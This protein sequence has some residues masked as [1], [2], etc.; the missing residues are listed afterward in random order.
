MNELGAAAASA[1]EIL[2]S[3][4]A[5][6]QFL[7]DNVQSYRRMRGDLKKHSMEIAVLSQL[8]TND[9]TQL[10]SALG[11]EQPHEMVFDLENQRWADAKVKKQLGASLA[12]CV[13]VLSDLDSRFEEVRKVTKA[14]RRRR[15]S[16][17]TYLALLENI[18]SDMR[19]I[20]QD[21]TQLCSTIS[22]NNQHAN[23]ENLAQIHSDGISLQHY[24]RVREASLL[25]HNALP[26][27]VNHK[28]GLY[29]NPRTVH[30]GGIELHAWASR[31]QECDCHREYVS[32]SVPCTIQPDCL[33]L[34]TE[35]Q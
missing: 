19:E 7:K 22:A 23:G 3:I 5:A 26:S 17:R 14:S 11:V 6:Q 32:P 25:L 16:K 2:R 8:I 30:T 28:L 33:R 18:V 21:F 27:E 15:L 1:M 29:L 10:I 9:A 35:Q 12:S 20:A 24:A 31:H 4:M 34:L 13:S